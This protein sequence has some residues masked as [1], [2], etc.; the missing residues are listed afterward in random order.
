VVSAALLIIAAAVLALAIPPGLSANSRRPISYLG[1]YE[2]GLPASFAGVT[3]FT[4][5]SG[6]TPDVVMYYSAWSTPFQASFAATAA[7]HDAV[8][9][10][11]INPFNVDL[12]AIAEGQYD[13]YL[14]T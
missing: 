14:S 1:L 4:A 10:V 7:E 12:T 3:A 9:L 2:R 11:Q 13:S 8:P 6:V 5:A